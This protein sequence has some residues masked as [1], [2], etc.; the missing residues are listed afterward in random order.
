MKN[1]LIITYVWPPARGIGVQRWLKLSK[2]LLKQEIKPIILTVNEKLANYHIGI[3]N[4]QNEEIPNDLFVY[5]TK[6][7]EPL[8]TII[9]KFRAKS[10]QPVG[11]YTIEQKS[12]FWK[13]IQS[14]RSNL[15]I[16]DAYKGWNRYAIKKARQIIHD[17]NV[18]I[19][20]TTGPPHSSHLI[21]LKLKEKHQIKWI[22]DFRDPWTDSRWF[23]NA[24]HSYFSKSRNRFLE[25][26]VLI[27][28]DK[29]FTIGDSLN[30]SLIKKSNIIHNSKFCVIPN[31][32]DKDD[33]K[34]HINSNAKVFNI[35]YCG[36]MEDSY[37]PYVFFDALKQIEEETSNI[38][39]NINFI[40]YITKKNKQ[41]LLKTGLNCRFITYV[42]HKDAI[43]YQQN[44][45]LLLLIIPNIINS[46]MLI[47]G[48]LFEYLGTQNNII[49]I[50]PKSGD[51]AKIIN[52]C[53]CGKTFDRTNTQE[54]K[55][56]ISTSISDFS[57][58]VKMETNE[59]E[60]NRY[61]REYQ[62]KLVK[63]EIEKLL[64]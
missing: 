18:K 52:E 9:N 41:E 56:Y 44:A 11:F 22:A 58:N 64:L 1:I 50:G 53:N 54:I 51:A 7:F 20:I 5:K 49:S 37:E 29:I 35:C 48:K 31:G 45:S 59:E 28:A 8:R 42:P 6:T 23:H 17:H 47:P 21:G 62:A 60:I 3:E 43:K 26:K 10:G 33:Y 2:Y 25:E 61:S 15:L 40:G 13:Y 14:I 46:N 30:H 34:K 4:G 12:G 16:P 57:D 27:N 63:N 19:I 39:I 24:G 38:E 55:N 32:Y 36:T